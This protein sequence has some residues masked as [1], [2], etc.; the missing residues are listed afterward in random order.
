[1]KFVIYKASDGF[2]SY[3]KPCE[4]A[5]LKPTGNGF[6]QFAKWEVEINSLEDL[7]SLMKETDNELI[8]SEDRIIIYDDYVE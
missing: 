4:K 7:L 2:N 3:P 6:Y 5:Y 1:M 8:L